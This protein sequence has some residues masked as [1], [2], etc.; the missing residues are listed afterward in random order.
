VKHRLDPV[1]QSRHLR[2]ELRAFCDTSPLQFDRLCG[3]P[4]LGQELGGV[5]ARERRGVNFV[6]LDLSPCDRAHLQGIGNGDSS[7][8]RCQQSGNDGRV[9]SCL[10]HHVIILRKCA[11]KPKY[12]IPVHR[13][14][15]AVFHQTVLEYGD[16]G[17]VPVNIQSNDSHKLSPVVSRTRRKLA[18]NT[19]ITDSRSQRNRASRRGSQITTRA[20]S[21]LSNRGLPANH[22]SVAPIPVGE[23]YAKWYERTQRG[24]AAVKSMPGNNHL[25]NRIRP[26]AL[27]RGNW[28][29]CG[30]LRAGQRAAN[31]MTLIQ[32]ALCRARHKALYAE[33]RT[34]PNGI[35]AMCRR[36]VVHGLTHAVQRCLVRHSPGPHR[37]S[38]KCSRR[39][40]G[41]NLAAEE[42]P[43]G[44]SFANA[45]SLI[46]MCA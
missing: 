17:E 34:M 12:R 27:G 15:A 41:R 19:T 7:H 3:H 14:A 46:A 45:A 5:Q 44:R 21:S 29:F 11:A 22:A 18:D 20:R 24:R 33:R 38:R 2:D 36:A 6:S 32:S 35:D 40:E 26:V 31:I 4:D 13:D 25:E 42:L 23:R 43:V 9:T 8:K 37:A 30:S 16:L 39:S 1:L 28:L 10:D